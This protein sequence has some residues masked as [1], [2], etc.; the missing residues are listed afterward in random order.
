[1]LVFMIIASAEA[2]NTSLCKSQF[3]LITRAHNC[4][5]LERESRNAHDF[6]PEV[7]EGWR[8]PLLLVGPLPPESRSL[9]PPSGVLAH[10]PAITPRVK[11]WCASPLHKAQARL[12]RELAG[13][14][15]WHGCS[16]LMPLSPAGSNH[17]QTCDGLH[18]QS[19]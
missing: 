1:M 16:L 10:E 19:R 11:I 13:L 5:I 17:V 6:F 12:P 18:N 15:S 4:G 14:P 2:K 3:N 8:L 9:P 7:S